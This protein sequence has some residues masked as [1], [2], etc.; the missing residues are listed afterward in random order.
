MLHALL[1]AKL[2]PHL[3]EPQRLEDALTSSVFGTLLLVEAWDLLGDWLLGTA[4]W[5]SLGDRCEGWFWPR[6]A[7]G[8]EPDVVLRLGDVLVVVE[9]K[10]R[11]SRHDLASDEEEPE[12]PVDQLVRQHLAVSPP[13]DNRPQYPASLELAV[14]NCELAQVFVVDGRRMRTAQGELEESRAL[15]PANSRL[16]LVTWQ[17]LYALLASDSTGGKR[18]RQDV[19]AYLALCGL[20]SFGGIRSAFPP[21]DRFLSLHSWNPLGRIADAPIS[22]STFAPRSDIRFMS[23]LQRWQGTECE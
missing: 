17:Q 12:R 19:R 2:E 14:R 3:P 5:N 22:L 8:V 18:W 21:V 1:H 13:Y 7:Y 4:S 6:L 20:A 16:S 10:Y 11:S 15:L 23:M 9:A